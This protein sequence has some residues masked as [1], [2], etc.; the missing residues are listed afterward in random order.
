MDSG[1][2]SVN[3]GIIELLLALLFFSANNLSTQATRRKRF[4]LR[5]LEQMLSALRSYKKRSQI[6]NF[7]HFSGDNLLD[8]QHRLT[9][10][11]R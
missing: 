1:F 4:W 9:I 8:Q 5:I 2:F 7:L 10:V 11:A 6:F 3:I